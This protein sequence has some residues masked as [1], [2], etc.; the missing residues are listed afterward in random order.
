PPVD[1]SAVRAVMAAGTP[2]ILTAC[3]ASLA[4]V[5]PLEFQR[6]GIDVRV[7]SPPRHFASVPEFLTMHY[8]DLDGRNAMRTARRM[9]ELLRE[10][11]CIFATA[12][13][14]M[15]ARLREIPDLG[16]QARLPSG[17]WPLARRYGARVFMMQ[18]GWH[19]GH[20]HTRL[21]AMDPPKK[22]LDDAALHALWHRDV[23]RVLFDAW[24]ED[25]RNIH[26][27]RVVVRVTRPGG[28]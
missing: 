9:V 5:L 11:A 23:L 22:D 26:Q 15:G 19:Q 27:N 3:H 6:S 10:G 8:A 20:L 1:W 16:V 14:Q 21:R 24:R 18:T 12:D 28:V 7:V 17:L 4:E 25:L 2:V 13:G